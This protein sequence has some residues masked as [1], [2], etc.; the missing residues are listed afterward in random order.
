V[1]K[2][3]GVLTPMGYASRSTFVIDKEGVVRKVYPKAD[4]AKHPEELLA[5]I[6]ENLA[7]K[8]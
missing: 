1:A 4:A 7:E 8:K 6:K 2:E 3:Y 5:W